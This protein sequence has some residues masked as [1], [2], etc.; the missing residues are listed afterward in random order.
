MKVRYQPNRQ[1][2]NYASDY[3]NGKYAR[4]ISLMDYGCSDKDIA[5]ATGFEEKTIRNIRL[6]P[7]VCASVLGFRE[8]YKR[9]SQKLGVEFLESMRSAFV[10]AMRRHHPDKEVSGTW[11]HVPEE[12]D[13][14]PGFNISDCHR[15]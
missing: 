1:R 15:Y 5:E 3:C 12:K 11:D 10:D 13:W 4:V 14:P 8:K 2:V 9:N 7:Q 6:N